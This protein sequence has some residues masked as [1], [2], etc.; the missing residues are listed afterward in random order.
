MSTG[1]SNCAANAAVF[2]NLYVELTIS[3]SPPIGSFT[4]T[5]M[6]TSL[7]LRS[8]ISYSNSYSRSES[9]L[10]VRLF[11]L[12]H[13]VERVADVQADLFVL[14]RVVDVIFAGKERSA[15]RILLVHANGSRGQRHS[16]TGFLFVLE[17]VEDLHGIFH[18]RAGLRRRAVVVGLPVHHVHFPQRKMRSVEQADLLRFL[19]EDR[20]PAI[21]RIEM[22]F[23]ERFLLERGG[24]IRALSRLSTHGPHFIHAILGDDAVKI[25]G[26]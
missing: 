3:Q 12:G 8:V 20:C 11:A 10:V 5:V 9:F 2:V 25:A 21:Q 7:W 1:T 4:S 24:S 13:D 6:G 26:H 14:R 16:Q 23:G 17:F 19:I 18:G 15:A 22:I